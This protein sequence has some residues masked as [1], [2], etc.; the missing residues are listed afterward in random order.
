MKGPLFYVLLG[1][2]VYNIIV[3]ILP[4][5][6]GCELLVFY[7]TL[8]DKG[9]VDWHGGTVPFLRYSPHL[10]SIFYL[11]FLVYRSVIQVK[12]KHMFD[13]ICIFVCAGVVSV[14][15]IIETF[16]NNDGSIYI[17]P[18]SI[19]ISTVFYYLFL[20]QKLNK[21]DPLTELF[22]RGSYFTDLSKMGSDITG[23]IQLDM[24]GL[25]YLNDNYGHLEGDKGLKCIA[26][27]ILDNAT[28]KMYSYR[29]GGDEFIV[30]AVDENKDNI[31][32]FI[33]K[34]KD[35]LKKT[36]YYCSI[37]Y[38][39]SEDTTDINEMFKLSEKRMYEDKAEFY[40]K[41]K[42]ERRQV[43]YIN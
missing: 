14:A 42:F 8:S 31:L 26:K 37:G 21:L 35:S 17:L 2:T 1:A 20:Y 25:K 12:R 23:I 36:K 32:K 4:F 33:S 10:I 41:A 34:F 3:N 11:I 13:A 28:S 5:I 30:L 40:K 38:A 29:V 16:F 7:F 22:N 39:L 19:G 9:T 15:T 18:S 27:T 6:S 43:S 24:N